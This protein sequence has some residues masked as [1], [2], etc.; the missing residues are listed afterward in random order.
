MALKLIGLRLSTVKKYVTWKGNEVEDGV[1]ICKIWRKLS[2]FK[3]CVTWKEN[4]VHGWCSL[5]C[6]EFQHC[7]D[8]AIMPNNCIGPWLIGWSNVTLYLEMT[9]GRETLLASLKIFKVMG[10][11]NL[12][13]LYRAEERDNSEDDSCI[14][15]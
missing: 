11:I 6:V 13:I 1:K 8:T 15:M 2:C 7:F 14:I 12:A 9:H 4:K 3:E 5:K 10:N